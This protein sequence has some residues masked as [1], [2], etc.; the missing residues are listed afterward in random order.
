M[1]NVNFRNSQRRKR[2]QFVADLRGVDETQLSAVSIFVKGEEKGPEQFQLSTTCVSYYGR[3]VC[4]LLFSFFFSFHR[5]P[6]N[7]AHMPE[8]WRVESAPAPGQLS[9]ASSDHF[10]S[11]FTGNF[12]HLTV[13]PRM[14]ICTPLVETRSPDSRQFSAAQILC[15]LFYRRR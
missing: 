8:H 5:P 12:S 4:S 1:G 13:R 9:S 3:G 10:R 11:S 2:E 6:R 15:F 14:Y 7:F